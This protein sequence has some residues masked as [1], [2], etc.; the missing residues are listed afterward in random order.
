[1]H[2]E[3]LVLAKN[4]V[5][6]FP[7]V[8]A[9]NNVTFDIKS[10]EIHGLVGQNGA[11]KTT[12]VKIIYGV[13]RPDYGKLYVNGKEVK[14][15][16]PRDARKH[17]IM[18]VN[19]EITTI[20]HLTVLENIFL[21][22]S[23]WNQNIF[24]KINYDNL[25]DKTEK[26]LSMLGV[27]IDANSKVMNLRVAEKMIVQ[28][29]AALTID[30]KV[31]LLDEPT[32]PLPPEEV[33]RLFD[34]MLQLRD[35][36]IGIVFITHRVKEVLQI[37]DRITVLRNGN[38]LATL[39]GSQKS[40]DKLIELMLGVDLNDFY[41]VRMYLTATKKSYEGQKPFL[42]LKNIYTKPFQPIDIPLK[43][44]NLKIFKGEI[45]AI[46]GL[47]GAGKTE[48]GKTIVG[49][50]NIEKGEIIIENQKVNIKSP[51][52]ALKYGIYY[53][54]EDRKNEGLIPE[55][56]VAANMIISALNEFT[57]LGFLDTA[58][59]Y[60]TSMEMKEKLNINMPSPYEK[61]TKLS[62]G[63]QQK[64]LLS[65]GLLIKPKLLILDEPTIGIDIGAKVE[66]RKA[67]YNIAKNNN[68][69]I[70]FLT[71]DPD[72]A[73]GLA[74]RIIIMRSGRIIADF[75]N[76]NLN[77]SLIINVMTG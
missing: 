56:N 69:T 50:Q 39:E 54:P 3:T 17:G 68:I 15:N 70:V 65:R 46:L 64:V 26:L 10:G 48:L 33:K 66:V 53:L 11:G 61:I 59:E 75:I 77:R 40:E 25:R 32:S 23:M 41:K 2:N 20:P 16:S 36:Q 8:I 18:L 71:S 22:G 28:I 51:V 52:H 45:L 58:K 76:E 4:I 57:H 5:K 67:I 12:L 63:N 55:L 44:I 31:I 21:L 38:K 13:Y 29:A 74:D 43:D 62:G 34:I 60:K 35:K 27:N 72:E 9:I 49:L 1:M 7:G 37:S 47:V 42:E 14:F 6:K 30:A 24:K 19:Q 73:L